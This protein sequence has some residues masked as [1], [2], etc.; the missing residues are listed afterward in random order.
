MA[1]LVE[2]ATSDMLAGPDW[3]MNMEICDIINIEPGHAKDSVK[4]V[5]KR[6]GNR[7]PKVQLLALV[8]L[9]TM[10]KNCGDIVHHHV[11]AKDVLHD[12]VKIAKRNKDAHVRDKILGLLDV[13]QEAFGGPS[14]RYPQYFM[15]YDELRRSGVMFP[16][17]AETV[18]PVFTPPQTHPIAANFPSPQHSPNR[19]RSRMEAFSPPDL[20]G[21]SLTEIQNAR[22]GMEVLSEMLNAV[23]PH[24]KQALRDEVI[25][26]L[27]EQCRTAER[28]VMQLVNSTSDEELLRQGLSLNDDLQKVLEK[29]DAIAS[30]SRQYS[31]TAPPQ[32]LTGSYQ[33]ERTPSRVRPQSQT[34]SSVSTSQMALPPPAQSQPKMTPP[35]TT[36]APVVDL[37]SGETIESTSQSAALVGPPSVQQS[38]PSSSMLAQQGGSHLFSHS[39][40]FQPAPSNPSFNTSPRQH[41]QSHV[42]SNGILPDPAGMSSQQSN[43]GQFP[44]VQT[45][46]P[47]Q[48][49]DSSYVVPWAQPSGHTLNPQQQALIFGAQQSGSQVEPSHSPQPLALTYPSH[50]PSMSQPASLQGYGSPVQLHQTYLSSQVQPQQHFNSAP[51]GYGSPQGTPQQI[52]TFNQQPPSI[53]LPPAP[54]NTEDTQQAVSSGSQQ[55]GHLYGSTVLSSQPLLPVQFS[56]RHQLFQQQRFAGQ[57]SPHIGQSSLSVQMQNLSLQ[58][59]G[60]YY[61]PM[62]TQGQYMQQAEYPLYQKQAAPMKETKPE[63]K[64]FKDLVDLAKTT[65]GGTSSK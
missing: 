39:A 65:K 21:L 52:P 4:A 20:P 37:L 10:I 53:H 26:E 36:R 5:K 58:G 43:Y 24:D 3:A 55:T 46:S 29:H 61:S 14:G 25:V 23:N 15:A 48:F 22:S 63:D 50:V 27:V 59:A 47:R 33:E 30:G 60:V 41:E 49:P 34:S 44:Q 13:W 11:A 28:R 42:Q 64:L 54:W 32:L 56:D 12:M 17:R 16:G 62:Q 57:T 2:K 51:Y 40:G 8:V 45:Q 6:L 9:E 18:A 1:S 7:N 31:P 19:M 35:A 38:Q